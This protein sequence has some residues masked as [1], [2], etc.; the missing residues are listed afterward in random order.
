ME[1]YT[2]SKEL[3]DDPHY[4]DQRRKYLSGLNDRMIDTPIIDIINGFNRLPYCFTLQCCYGHFLHDK[5]K[6]VHN[7]EPLPV[8]TGITQ[9]EYRIA[10]VA[11]CIEN[12][13]LGK[14]LLKALE[15]ITLI[16]PQNIQ[17]C[18]AEWFWERLVNSY[19]LQVEPDRYKNQDTAI[20][21][22]QEA[23]K[24]EKVRNEFFLQLRG[25]LQKV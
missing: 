21:D 18:S 13:D 8:R 24:I 14:R 9:V 11:F 7:L 20:L 10:Y 5:Q 1:T 25:L 4:Q 22:Y 12:N 15:K 3:V 16:D 19:A 23:L 17:L 6:D 2:E